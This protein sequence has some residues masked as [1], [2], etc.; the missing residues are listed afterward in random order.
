MGKFFLHECCLEIVQ[1]E[2]VED[3]K[4]GSIVEG[5]GYPILDPAKDC[6]RGTNLLP[7]IQPC[8]KE[9][10]ALGWALQHGPSIAQVCQ[11]GGPY[12]CTQQ[13]G[14]DSVL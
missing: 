1:T 14:P 6:V 10:P 4:S 9:H 11:S 13:P 3:T 8:V 2:V 5:E 7:L 12:D